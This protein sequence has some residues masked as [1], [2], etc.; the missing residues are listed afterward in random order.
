MT[1]LYDKLYCIDNSFLK[2]RL[3]KYK[4]DYPDEDIV[5]A[6]PAK[7][8]SRAT[9]RGP[10][11]DFNWTDARRTNFILTDKKIVTGEWSI[12]LQD[13]KQAELDIFESVSGKLMV[14]KVKT[15]Y[16]ANY[17]FSMRFDQEL[18]SQWVL[19]V[20]PRQIHVKIP[21]ALKIAHNKT[22]RLLILLFIVGCAIYY[23]WSAFQ[24]LLEF[25]R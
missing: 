24:Q 4:A 7:A 14:L 20:Q 16:G 3:K 17:Q 13:I 18:L 15:T 2:R 9:E 11:V 12:K 8:I 10:A 1:H 5:F 21:V 6:A 22:L 23:L 19:P 25:F